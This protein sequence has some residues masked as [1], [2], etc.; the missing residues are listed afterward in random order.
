MEAATGFGDGVFVLL[1]DGPC[2]A[3]LRQQA[4]DLG[5]AARVRFIPRVPFDQLHA[6]TCS[7]DVGLCLI[8]GTG[9]SFYHSLPNKLFEYMMAG[10]PVVASDF[11]EMQR[12]VA[13]TGCG[14]T[15]PPTDKGA[16]QQAIAGLLGDADRLARCRRASL[17]AAERYNWEAE[18]PRLLEAYQTL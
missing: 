9:R 12:V 5:L 6:Y 2:E 14:I 3:A 11:P 18:A 4:E 1:G 13:E 16:V 7:A 15:V 10:L 8:K 17:T